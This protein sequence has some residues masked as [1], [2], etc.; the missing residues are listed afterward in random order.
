[1]S[2]VAVYLEGGG[3]TAQAK[4][5]IRLGMGEFLVDLREKA[6]QKRWHW[7]IVACGSRIEAKDAFLHAKRSDPGTYAVLLVDAEA[8]CPDLRRNTSPFEMVGTSEESTSE[9][10]ISWFR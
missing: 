3:Q 1:M 6:R 9:R 8:S 4:A 2:G 5:E 10:S 7:R